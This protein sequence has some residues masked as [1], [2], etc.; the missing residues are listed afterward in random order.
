MFARRRTFRF[1]AIAISA[2]LVA[3]SLATQAAPAGPSHFVDLKNVANTTDPDA[4]KAAAILDQM[5]AALGGD[6]WMKLREMESEGRSASFYH[7]NPSGGYTLFFAFHQFPEADAVPHDRIEATKKRNVVEIVN[8]ADAWEV[9]FQ[10]KHRLDK[11]AA[12]D[13]IRRRD[14][15]IE[16]LLRV[17]LRRPG[18]ALFYGGRKMA[19]RRLA[20]EVTVLTADNDSITLLVD[21]DTHLPRKRTFQ[22]RDPLYHDRNTED[23]TYDDWHLVQG[24]PSSFLVTRYKNGD[25]ARQS[26]LS[27]ISYDN[28]LPAT[29]FDPD[30]AAASVAR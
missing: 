20:D 27:K 26:Y 25:M 7:G 14:H 22:W 18:N 19:D 17:W 12:E 5:V 23:E 29:S 15:S 28:P 2:L 9:T 1:A 11:D 16:T 13:F 24:L 6:R 3:A 21:T 30:I 8:G 10:G 4:Q